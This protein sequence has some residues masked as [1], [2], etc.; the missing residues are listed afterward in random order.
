M[1]M[2]ISN[3]YNKLTKEDRKIFREKVMKVCDLPYYTFSRKMRENLW[4]KLEVEAITKLIDHG[5]DE[6]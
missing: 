3:Y 4:S 5:M 6:S 1:N 2:V